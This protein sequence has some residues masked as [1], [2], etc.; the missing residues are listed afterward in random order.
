[1]HRLYTILFSLAFALMA[2]AQSADALFEHYMELRKEGKEAT[3]VLLQLNTSY[4][5][6][7]PVAQTAFR[8]KL[9]DSIVSMLKE[10]QKETSVSLIALYK[11]IAPE[12]DVKLADLYYIEG[13]IYAEQQDTTKLKFTINTLEDFSV[14]NKLSKQDDLQILKKELEKMRRRNR[15]FNE[16]NGYWVST[17]IFVHSY[18]EAPITTAPVIL[19]LPVLTSLIQPSGKNIEGQKMDM[20]MYMTRSSI[21]K[22]NCQIFLPYA[23]DSLY[24]CWCTEDMHNFD[25]QVS[26]ALRNVAGLGSSAVAASLVDRKSGLG[27]KVQAQMVGGLI[28]MGM[29]GIFNL[30]FQ[31]SKKVEI[32]ELKVKIDSENQMT[33][34]AT[35]HRIKGTANNP[36]SKY[37]TQSQ[38]IQMIRWDSS[39]PIQ[40]MQTGHGKFIPQYTPK[41]MLTLPPRFEGG[42]LSGT[43]NEMGAKDFNR[44]KALCLA[45]IEQPELYKEA[46]EYINKQSQWSLK[47]KKSTV[48]LSAWNKIQAMKMLRFHRQREYDRKLALGEN[49]EQL[50]ER[51]N[52]P[53][54]G[55]NL[56]HIDTSDP[57]YKGI[58]TTHGAEISNIIQGTFYIVGLEKGDIIC[59]LDGEPIDY[60]EDLVRFK[61]KHKIGDKVKLEYIEKG[62]KKAETVEITLY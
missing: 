55:V 38:N 37:E 11:S 7:K 30:M 5:K 36:V 40:F 12:K 24:V 2:H 59:S 41:V 39:W 45:N 44:N 32:L 4:N 8:Q 46:C 48:Y 27:T 31:P 23:E 57:M 3:E 50:L 20:R 13:C 62:K 58:E 19:G 49:D 28:E 29:N 54:F 35:I 43:I 56:V 17:N 26:G 47:V 16:L 18:K 21:D 25:P 53:F 22:L 34:T 15:L 51:I 6:L 9:L 61:S 52:T 1:M 60:H 14:K 33:G 42:L 10:E